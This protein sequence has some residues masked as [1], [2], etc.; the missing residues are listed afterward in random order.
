MITRR[1]SPDRLFK[2]V[3]R[4][5]RRRENNKL[6]R[7]LRRPLK[8]IHTAKAGTTRI[9]PITSVLNILLSLS[10]FPS[11]EHEQQK[12]VLLT[13]S[14]TEQWGHLQTEVMTSIYDVI[15]CLSP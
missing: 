7:H 5:K 13:S 11:P 8:V 4:H 10:H 15:I 1:I 3:Q 14:C 6:Q 9:L 2:L 12:L